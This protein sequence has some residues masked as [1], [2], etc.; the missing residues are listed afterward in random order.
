MKQGLIPLIIAMLLAVG[1]GEKYPDPAPAP[2]PPPIQPD[3]NNPG[4]N[5]GE[6]ELEVPFKDVILYG[7]FKEDFSEKSSG[8]LRFTPKANGDDFRYYSGH[9]SLSAANTD[10]MMMRI[11]PTDGEGLGKGSEV[12][13][14][15]YTFYGSYSAKARVPDTRKAQKNLGAAAGLYAYDTDEKFGHSE[16]DFELRVSDPTKV[17]LAAWTGKQGSLNRISRTIDLAKGTILDC[18]Y[19]T[20]TTEKG[21][22]SDAQNKPSSIT[23][24]SDFDASK[25]FYIY[26][27]DWYPDRI[28]WWIK[29]NENSEKVTLW[30]YEPTE[31]FQGTYS[32]AGIPVLPV[33]DSFCFWHSKTRLAE[34]LKSATE[35]P[36]YPFELEIDW[37]SYEPY[38]D[39][40]KEWLEK[41]R[42]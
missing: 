21:K 28:T 40:N 11:D 14:K 1:C 33:H 15:D 10:V 22:L 39:L 30:D 17:Y 34:G 5:T 27:F 25:R 20:G 42:K 16:I 29:L 26:G 35:A 23:A 2:P 3:E 38:D 32:P 4:D 37:M 9:P 7:K 12:T 19:G 18:S 6:D 36:K 13:T 8:L 24:I 41:G 31:L